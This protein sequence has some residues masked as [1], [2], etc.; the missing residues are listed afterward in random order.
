M[1]ENMR[2]R[3]LRGVNK[4]IGNFFKQPLYSNFGKLC[5]NHSIYLF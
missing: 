5:D 4:S 3:L 2:N 1:Q